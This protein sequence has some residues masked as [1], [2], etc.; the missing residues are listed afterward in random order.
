MTKRNGVAIGAVLVALLCGLLG[1]GPASASSGTQGVTAT[2]IR[3]GVPY[4]NVA[5][6]KSVGVSINW[7]NVTDAYKAVIADVNAHGGINGRKIVPFIVAVDPTAAAPAATTCTTLTQ[8]DKVFAVIA[9]LQP[10]CYL[11]A[12]VPVIAGI[13]ASALGTGL[14]QNFALAPPASTYD[15]LQLSIFSKQGVFKNKKVGVFA[16]VTTDDAELKIVQA[17]LSKL[18]VNVVSTA[19]DS[20]PQGDLS[21]EN[22]QLAVITQ[23]FQ[24]SG[25]NEVVAV[26]YGSS[27]WP[28]GLSAIQSSYNPPWV[29]TSEADFTGDVGGSND[30]KYLS[31]VVTSSPLAGGATIWANPGTQRCV[32]LVRKAYPSDHINAFSATLPSSQATWTGIEQACTDVALFTAIAKAAGKHLTLASFMHAG[33]GLRNVLIPGSSAPISFG[34]NRPY[35]LGPVYMVHYDPNTKA[36]VVA[37]KPVAQ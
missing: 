23:R 19:V 34:P 8:D 14:A 24:A 31:N 17:S 12:G 22:E 28:E 4:V 20:A 21:A 32:K 9:P 18:H 36:I 3:V 30:P 37:S 11:Q 27:I 25:V 13:L 10:A 5:A 33:Y 29:A 16:G 1:V 15:P 35:A 7:G 6:V 2:T 26:G